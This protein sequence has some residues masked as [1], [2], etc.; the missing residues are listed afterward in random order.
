MG[1]DF[2]F[3]M[4]RESGNELKKRNRGLGLAC[5][6]SLFP[7]S[8]IPKSLLI[9]DSLKDLRWT[10]EFVRYSVMVLIETLISVH[11]T[12]SQ[13]SFPPRGY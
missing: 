12:P 2:V 4:E 9:C 1:M 5:E 6:L 10:P 8:Y 13:F 7:S 3:L 11:L